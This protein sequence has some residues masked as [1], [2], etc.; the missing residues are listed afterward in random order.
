MTAV[1]VEGGKPT[2]SP[3]I[4]GH[5]RGL[6]VLAGTE[7]WDRI[8]FH[9]MQALLVLYM[10]GQLFLPGHIERIVGFADFRAAIEEVTGPLSVQ[11]LASQVFGLYAGLVYLTP[12]IGGWLGDR[13]FGRKAMVT[14]GAL[15]MTAGHFC[16]A[17]DQ[18]FLL[19]MLF[20]ILGAGALRGNLIPQVGELYRRDD[21]RRDVAFQLY[22]SMINLGAFIAP[23]F[24]GALAQAYSWHF[25]FGFAGVGMLVGLTVYLAGQSW[26]I[27]VDPRRVERLAKAPLTAEDR[28]RVIALLGL[29]PVA[30]LFWIAQSQVWNTY[31]LWVR[32]HIQLGIGSFTVPVPWL[33]ALDGLAPFICLPPM[34]AFWRWQAARG[35][36]PGE[37]LKAAIGCFIFAAGTMLLAVA[38]FAADA[39]GRSSLLWAVA[40]HLTSN[41][42]WLYFTPTMVA[43]FTRSAPAQVSATLVGVNML[44]TFF[45]SLICGRIGGLYESLTPFRFWSLHAAIVAA[46]GVIFLTIGWRFAGA[47]GL[48]DRAP[49]RP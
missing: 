31:N 26:V 43:I 1:T 17:F 28:H 5:P 20:L 27:P 21:D 46:G 32:D 12:V 30:M 19:A 15:L 4:F 16:M 38:G 22:Y 2:A 13:W 41:L 44:A 33:Q 24:T 35:Q 3:E 48:K 40:F 36:E 25:G 10:V 34:L 45:G 42:G 39:A 18:S 37:F 29:L 49:A 47:Y 9:G 11:A 23:V 8:S 14:L 7:L 6:V